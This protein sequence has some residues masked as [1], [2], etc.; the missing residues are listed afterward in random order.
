M[1]AFSEILLSIID[2]TSPAFYIHRVSRQAFQV[3]MITAVLT[4][5][6]LNWN[7]CTVVA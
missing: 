3:D 7:F 1:G 2:A 4:S 5:E 6:K